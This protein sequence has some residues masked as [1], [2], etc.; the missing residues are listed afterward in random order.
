[1]RILTDDPVPENYYKS[2]TGTGLSWETESI[3]EPCLGLL[4]FKGEP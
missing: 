4:V 3:K 2:T 1:M